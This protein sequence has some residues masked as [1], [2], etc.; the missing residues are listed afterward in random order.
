MS[1]DWEAERRKIAEKTKAL[2]EYLDDMKVNDPERYKKL[3]E[4]E[5]AMFQSWLEHRRAN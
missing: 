4:A 5:R 3:E 1:I 2:H